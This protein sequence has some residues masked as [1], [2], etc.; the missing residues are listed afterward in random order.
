MTILCIVWFP[1]NPLVL[2]GFI[3]VKLYQKNKFVGL[4]LSKKITSNI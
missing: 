3:E 1:V 4:K 2:S